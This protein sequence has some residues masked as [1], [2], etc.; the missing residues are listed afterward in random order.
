MLNIGVVNSLVLFNKVTN[1][2]MT[3]TAF[4]TILVENL[5][6]KNDIM[7]PEVTMNHDFVKAGRSRCFKCYKKTVSEKGRTK[8]FNKS[9]Y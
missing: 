7:P 4:R 3:I 8:S 1:S 9:V 5:V 2:K 6:K